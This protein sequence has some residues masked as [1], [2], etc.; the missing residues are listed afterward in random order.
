MKVDK[1]WYAH[2][3]ITEVIFLHSRVGL[4]LDTKYPQPCI[5]ESIIVHEQSLNS[6]HATVEDPK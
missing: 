6:G 4:S 5:V 2:I 1:G 3:S